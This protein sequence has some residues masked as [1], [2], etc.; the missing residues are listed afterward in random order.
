[1]RNLSIVLSIVLITTIH[2]YSQVTTTFVSKQKKIEAGLGIGLFLSEENINFYRLQINKRDLFFNR[3]GVY[4]TMELSNPSSIY[5]S[6]LIGLSYRLNNNFS[7]QSA[8][9]FLSK[10]SIF[11]TKSFRKE[12]SFAYH[13]I[14]NPLTYTLG[15]SI[16]RGPT[17]TV[18]FK[19]FRKNK[20]EKSIP[21]PV[22]STELNNIYSIPNLEISKSPSKDELEDSISKYTSTLN[23]PIKKTKV[24]QQFKDN[25]P[26]SYSKTSPTVPS[27]Q[28]IELLCSENQLSNKYN[29]Y[30]LSEIDKL[31]LLN[32]VTFLDSNK[33]YKLKIIGRA[34]NI[35]SESFNLKLGQKRAD[36]ARDFLIKNGVNPL[37]IISTSMGESKSQNANTE[38]ERQLARKTI[39]KIISPI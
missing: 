38:K 29:R 4:Y 11:K 21:Q 34:D 3:L 27:K 18:N 14:S 25:T 7:V 20:T 19:L 28:E 2:A 30:D 9:G 26:V 37:Q 22:E 16:A 17:L 13:P 39:F 24:E 32:F 23:A 33:K 15:Y 35:G 36:K 10:S 12:I 1:M 5:F 6:D 8:A 31:K